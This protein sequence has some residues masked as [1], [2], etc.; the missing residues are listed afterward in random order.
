[1]SP[2]YAEGMTIAVLE[3]MVIN[4][5]VIAYDLPEYHDAFRKFIESGQL[6][7]FPKGDTTSV[8]NYILSGDFLKRKF[9]NKLSDYKWGKIFQSEY[10]EFIRTN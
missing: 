7:L 4:K 2:S 8:A 10:E 1:L 6:I 9:Q 5:P 3:A